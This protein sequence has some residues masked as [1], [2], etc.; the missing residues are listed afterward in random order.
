MRGLCAKQCRTI[1]ASCIKTPREVLYSSLFSKG[2]PVV[3]FASL[4]SH[5]KAEIEALQTENEARL[6]TMA[7]ASGLA[8]CVSR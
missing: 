3:D 2:F 7:C 4:E 5:L 8:I 1:E 6:V